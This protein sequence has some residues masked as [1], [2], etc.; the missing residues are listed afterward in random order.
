MPI[1]FRRASEATISYG[2]DFVRSSSSATGAIS[3]SAKSRTVRLISS[4]SAERSKSIAPAFSQ[5][6]AVGAGELDEQA[7]AVAGGALADI[8][9]F[10]LPRRAGDVEVRPRHLADELAQ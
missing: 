6:L 2:K 9:A 7:H 8:G 5:L 10:E 3:P 1:R 4:C